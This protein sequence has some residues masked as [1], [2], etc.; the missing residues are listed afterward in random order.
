M[1][2]PV[3]TMLITLA[4]AIAVLGFTASHAISQ[5]FNEIQA[6]IKPQLQLEKSRQ[7]RQLIQ[8][9]GR[10]RFD[11]KN[12]PGVSTSF[13]ADLDGEPVEDQELEN[14]P[15]LNL[16]IEGSTSRLEDTNPLRAY[17]GSQDSHSIGV[18][19]AI[20]DRLTLGLIGNYSESDVDNIFTP[21]NSTTEAVSFGPYFAYFLTDTTVL[22][23]SF[24]YSW[25]DNGASSGG[26]FANYDSEGWTANSTL[27]SYFFAGN[28]L[29]AP[30][31]GLSFNEERDEAYIDTVATLFPASTIRTSTMNFGI[32]ASSTVVLPNG[33]EMEPSIGIEGEWTFDRSVDATSS[34]AAD[35]SEFDA[36]LAFGASF[37]LSD[38]VSLEFAGNYA[39]LAK[40]DYESLTGSIRLSFAF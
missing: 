37:Q 17:D 3:R 38:A 29:L 18:D 24:L 13:G 28:V 10:D 40:S 5:E 14:T 16:W 39:G 35:T 36:N 22:T 31:V 34:V 15:S 20:T 9:I 1:L 26:V 30:S 4:T 19:T 2:I 7:I 33:I 12:K 27:T 21:A 23:G 32:S 25:T 6:V 11:E 8:R